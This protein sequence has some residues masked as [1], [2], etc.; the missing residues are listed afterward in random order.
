MPSRVKNFTMEIKRVNRD[1]FFF[2]PNTVKDLQN[3]LSIS[4]HIKTTKWSF[5]NGAFLVTFF[6]LSGAFGLIQFL[7]AS[8][9]TSFLFKS[10]IRKKLLY[11]PVII[12]LKQLVLH[13]QI[14]MVFNLRIGSTPTTFKLVKNTIIFV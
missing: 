8:N 11:E 3:I 7:E 10:N 4:N 13:H 12:A 6:G 2:L 9:V 1:F 5:I 14:F